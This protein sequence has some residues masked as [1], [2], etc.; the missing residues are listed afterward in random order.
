MIIYIKSH[1]E[2]I[3]QKYKL[4]SYVLRTTT[5]APAPSAQ[6]IQRI[7]SRRMFC[8][9]IFLPRSA[10]GREKYDLSQDADVTETLLDAFEATEAT[11]LN[12]W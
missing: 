2:N 1:F 10:I 12:F 7:L 4:Q 3:P 6:T 9:C 8:T 5:Q 11:Q